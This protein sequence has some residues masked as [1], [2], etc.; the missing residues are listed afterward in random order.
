MYQKLI[1][2]M[3]ETQPIVHC[4]TNYVTVAD[5]AN[6]LLACGASPIMADDEREAA[7]ISSIAGALYLNIG[8]LNAR[9]VAA[10]RVAGSRAAE[11]RIP[12]VLDPVGA[13]ASALRT[14]TVAELLAN[15]P[16]AIVR[17]NLSELRAIAGLDVASRGV[18][19]AGGDEITD[20][21]LAEVA[22]LIAG[23]ARH[24]DG[25][26]AVSGAID[27]VSDGRRTLAIRGGDPQMTRITG[28]GCML[29]GVIAAM[30]AANPEEPLAATAAAMAL[31]KR[32]G[33]RAAAT[34]NGTGSFRTAFI[35]AISDAEAKGGLRIESLA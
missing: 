25:I 11:R 27:L 1:E 35:D 8:T 33:E 5:V 3:R 17:G 20:G 13:G 2:T 29:T 23:R 19:A 7:A 15:L 9:T 10:M 4:I 18:D 31:M 16:I 26:F 28:A 14:D 21:N 12:I 24:Y 30:A 22:A 6:T 34:A 32:A